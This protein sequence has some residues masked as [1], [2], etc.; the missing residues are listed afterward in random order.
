MGRRG[1]KEGLPDV[2]VCAGENY[3]QLLVNFYG[4]MMYLLNRFI[5]PLIRLKLLPEAAT[6]NADSL[7]A[8]A[9]TNEATEAPQMGQPI[10]P[11]VQAPPPAEPRR[12][13]SVPGP[14]K[15]GFDF[16]G[17]MAG[18]NARGAGGRDKKF[19]VTLSKEE[20]ALL[21]EPPLDMPRL[22]SK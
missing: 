4:H 19:M 17:M 20:A 2:Y 12:P 21:V 22:Y 10:E 9:E 7:P 15:M 11:D 16:E 3:L 14:F 6:K 18:L 5:Y 8:T 13:G 1:G